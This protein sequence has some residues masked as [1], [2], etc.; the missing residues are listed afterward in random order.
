MTSDNCVFCDVKKLVGLQGTDIL[1]VV[2]FPPLNPVT[3]GHMLFV[4][5]Q[6]FATPQKDP[7]L[8]GQVFAAAA[9]WGGRQGVDYNLIVNAGP[10]A[11]QTVNHMH[12]HYVPRS[13]SDSLKLPWSDQDKHTHAP[14]S[15][16]PNGYHA[17]FAV[18]EVASCSCG[19]NLALKLNGWVVVDEKKQT[20]VFVRQLY[21]T[22]DNPCGLCGE[23]Y[24]HPNHERHK[25]HAGPFDKRDGESSQ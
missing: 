9:Y 4:N 22:L 23:K 21:Q 14:L 11:S 16:S 19:K 17:T 10:D 1:G 18:G 7:I 13:S 24:N 15:T 3:P 20:H 8:A 25:G 6:H 2:K 12:I 5:R